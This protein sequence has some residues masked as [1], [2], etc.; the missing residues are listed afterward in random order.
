MK[1][2]T[3]GEVLAA[4]G[5]VVATVITIVGLLWLIANSGAP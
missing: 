3:L 5:A 1:K 4:V 2:P